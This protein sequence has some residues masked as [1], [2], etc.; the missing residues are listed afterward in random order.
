MVWGCF[1]SCSKSSNLYSH[2]LQGPCLA[3]CHYKVSPCSQ[4]PNYDS[5]SK[6]LPSSVP[7]MDLASLFE[8]KILITSQT[9][10]LFLTAKSFSPTPLY[11]FPSPLLHFFN[12]IVCPTFLFNIP[13]V[14]LYSQSLIL[15]RIAARFHLKN[16]T[17]LFILN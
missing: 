6:S 12:S 1:H 9:Q 2:R 3:C 8:L 15:D 17:R 4:I 10:H 11:K 16:T 7:N 5:T 14:S 13:T